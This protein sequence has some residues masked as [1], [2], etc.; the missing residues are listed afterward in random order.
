MD[1]YITILIDDP[2]IEFKTHLELKDNKRILFSGRFGSGKSYFLKHF[3]TRQNEYEVFFVNPVNYQVAKNEDIFELIKFDLI[4]ELLGKGWLSGNSEKINNSLL[5]QFFILNKS[6]DILLD[7]LSLIPKVGKVGSIGKSLTALHKSFNE[8]KEEISAKTDLEKAELFIKSIDSQQ[9]S[10]YELDPTTQIIYS[11]LKINK[12]EPKETVLVID[13]LDR[14]DPEHIFRLFNVFSSHFTDQPNE[15][16]KF[17]F[18]KIILVCDIE[19]IS[20]IFYSKYGQDVDFSGYIDKFYSYRCFNFSNEKSIWEAI[21]LIFKPLLSYHRNQKQQL[22]LD[23]VK[24]FLSDF[25]K[26]KAINIR[27]LQKIQQ[28]ENPFTKRKKIKVTDDF[29]FS[30]YDFGFLRSMLLLMEIFGNDVQKIRYYCQKCQTSLGSSSFKN[31]NHIIG[32]LGPFIDITQTKFQYAVEQDI[33][34]SDLKLVI[35]FKMIEQGD[36]VEDG[37][38]IRMEDISIRDLNGDGINIGIKQYYSLIERIITNLFKIL[39]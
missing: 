31:L 35:H 6:S 36:P 15:D 32:F 23:T 7:L 12:P 37:N 4:L 14:I 25:I 10:I 34:V 17:G 5:L 20:K 13:D 9:G 18:D 29:F 21:D 22:T 19:N 39:S 16:N 11:S 1:K 28:F 33:V 3:F 30:Q 8:Y 26:A 2:I 27:D 24:L 38:R